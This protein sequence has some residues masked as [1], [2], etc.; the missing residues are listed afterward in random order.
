MAEA[1]EAVAFS[2]T[3]G[4]EGIVLSDLFS[5]LVMHCIVINRILRRC[6]LRCIQSTSLCCLSFMETSLSSNIK[7]II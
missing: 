3:V 6:K 7:F 1:H 2:F 4:H 5:N